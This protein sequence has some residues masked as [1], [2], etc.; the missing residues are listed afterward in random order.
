MLFR[1]SELVTDRIWDYM[2]SLRSEPMDMVSIPNAQHHVLLDQ[3]L[4]FI[5]ALQTQLKRWDF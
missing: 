5:E 1:S 3:P 2:R 4:A